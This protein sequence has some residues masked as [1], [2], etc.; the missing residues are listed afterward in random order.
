[1][2][3]LQGLCEASCV[4]LNHIHDGGMRD[5]QTDC[6]KIENTIDVF[7]YCKG[8]APLD[9]RFHFRQCIAFGCRSNTTCPEEGNHPRENDL[10]G[11]EAGKL[12]KVGEPYDF[13]YEVGKFVRFDS[14]VQRV[15]SSQAPSALPTTLP[16]LVPSLAPS[17][18]PSLVPTALPSLM[19]TGAPTLSSIVAAESIL[20]FWLIPLIVVVIIIV[21][22]FVIFCI[23][24]TKKR[25][26]G[27]DG[28]ANLLDPQNDDQEQDVEDNVQGDENEKKDEDQ[29]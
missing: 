16:S 4:Q 9:D 13:E 7:P 18:A 8:L 26:D 11:C 17:L 20:L 19:P 6:T 27:D 2:S 21:L 10:R 23:K 25:D 28:G 3:F 22:L 15:D 24:K 29:Q 5:G 1:M 12:F 14:L